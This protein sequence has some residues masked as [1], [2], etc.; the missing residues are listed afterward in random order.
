MNILVIDTITYIVKFV[1][2]HTHKAPKNIAF[3]GKSHYIYCLIKEL[4]IDNSVGNP[5]YNRTTLT[6]EEILDNHRS[7]LCSFG[8]STKD[9]DD[10]LD[11]PSFYWIPN[12]HKCPLAFKQRYIPGSAKC[13][14]KPL[15]KILTCILSAVKTGLQ[16]YCDTSHSRGG[17]NQMWILKNSKDLIEYLQFRSLSSCNS[18]KTFD[19]STLYT[20]ISHSK[21]KDKLRELVQLC[22]IKK[23]GQRRYK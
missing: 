16:S 14:A 15:S 8:I 7:V 12:L 3:M 5:A 1:T 9:E 17:V 21:L 10:E 11:L 2:T 19:F 6:K 18:I 23:N 13:S 4:S 20:T 22:F